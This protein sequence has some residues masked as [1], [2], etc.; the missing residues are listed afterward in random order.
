MSK[1]VLGMPALRRN[2]MRKLVC[3]LTV[4][5]TASLGVLT[6]PSA[7]AK[8]KPAPKPVNYDALL[9]RVY[10]Y[11]DTEYAEFQKPQPDIA[12]LMPFIAPA[13]RTQYQ[14][15]FENSAA[16][17]RRYVQTR[18]VPI[19][20]KRAIAIKKLSKTKVRIDYCYVTSLQNTDD[21]QKFELDSRS[22]P[23]VGSRDQI[24]WINIK[25]VW[26]KGAQ[27]PGPLLTEESQCLL[28]K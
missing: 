12:K 16:S 13:F 5:V 11:F 6:V 22:Y 15:V 23:L 4:A 1:I 28:A 27:T 2:P 25:N 9:K 17:P 21:P 20:I 18:S 7:E 26:Y 14:K 24:E 8:K 3:L 19:D 10:S